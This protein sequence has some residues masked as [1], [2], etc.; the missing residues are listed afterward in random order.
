M[1]AAVIVTMGEDVVLIRRAQRDKAYGRW[2]LPGGFVDRGEPVPTAARREV[3]EEL[4]VTV[5]IVGLIGVYSYADEPVVTVVYE[6]T[7]VDGEELSGEAGVE[8]LE[9]RRH[10]RS[11]IPWNDLGFRSTVDALEMFAANLHRDSD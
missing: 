10:R 4:G 7:L 1:A 11:E 3:F 5:E 2:I 8:A 9:V 6:A